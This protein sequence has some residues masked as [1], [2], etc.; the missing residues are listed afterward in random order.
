MIGDKD[1]HNHAPSLHRPTIPSLTL[2]T[3]TV[4]TPF[5]TTT[6]S[7]FFFVIPTPI[8]CNHDLPPAVEKD[9]GTEA[10]EC[11]ASP[12]ASLH[13]RTAEEGGREGSH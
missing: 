7:V 6:L 12:G 9:V 5:H 8:Y 1:L 2:P 4:T 13:H 10:H 11:N 3:L